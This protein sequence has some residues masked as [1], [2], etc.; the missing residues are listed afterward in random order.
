MKLM[1]CCLLYA[2]QKTQVVCKINSDIFEHLTYLFVQPSCIS[3]LKHPP[4]SKLQPGSN[5]T[6]SILTLISN[7]FH[8]RNRQTFYLFPFHVESTI[9][10]PQ[11]LLFFLFIVFIQNYPLRL[12]PSFD[13]CKKYE[14]V[15]QSQYLMYMRL[16]I[17]SGIHLPSTDNRLKALLSCF[18]VF[19]PKTKHHRRCQISSASE[20]ERVVRLQKRLFQE[21]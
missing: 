5:Q 19:H 20:K 17:T 8:P 2:S 13:E 14:T 7:P 10:F 12:L 4:A 6:K 16:Q 15:C 9:S 11:L 3:R 21:N 1:F 18:I